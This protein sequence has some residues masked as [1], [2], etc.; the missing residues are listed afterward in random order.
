MGALPLAA[1]VLAQRD[2][3]SRRGL[4]ELCR[5]LGPLDLVHVEV[6]GRP[7]DRAEPAEI[8]AGA[9]AHVVGEHPTGVGEHDASPTHGDTQ[10]VE[11]LGIDVGDGAVPVGEHRV[12]EVG[13]HGPVPVDGPVARRQRHTHGHLVAVERDARRWLRRPRRARR[14]VRGR[15]RRAARAAPRQAWDSP[16]TRSPR[17]GRPRRARTRSP[18][19]D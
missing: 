3:G 5:V 13:Q 10:V 1:E 16:S 14:P 12:A 18:T 9:L 17:R 19:G 8:L 7:R 4:V 2:Q 11:E 6:A 15:G